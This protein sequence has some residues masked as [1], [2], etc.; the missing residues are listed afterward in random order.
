MNDTGLTL[1]CVWRELDGKLIELAEDPDGRL[2]IYT[3]QEQALSAAAA[4]PAGPQ[5]WCITHLPMT[6]KR[7]GKD[8][9]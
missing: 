8:K 9:L 5:P 6:I 2:F 7:K 3:D 1:W 4:L